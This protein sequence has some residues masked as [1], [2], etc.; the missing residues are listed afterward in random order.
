[1]P[2]HLAILTDFPEE[3]WRSMDLCGGMLLDH[4]PGDGPL[5]VD[6]G[7][8]CPPFRRLATRLPVVGRWHAAFNADRLLN[9]F[10]LFPQYARL[11]VLGCEDN[12]NGCER[13][14]S[15]QM[16]WRLTG[17]G[18]LGTPQAT[19]DEI[20][21]LTSVRGIAAL[22]VVLLHFSAVLF[23]VLPEASFL[24]PLTD[25]G[26]FAVPLFFILSGY[27]LGLRYLIRLRSPT[28]SAAMRFWWLR[29]GRVYPV[30]LCTLA[31]SLGMVAR[32]GWPADEGH[33]IGR[34]VANCLL[35]HAWECNF[36]LSWNYPSWSIS[37]EWFAYLIFP[38]LAFLLARA[39]RTW[40]A[41]L[42]G[43]ACG[44]SVG[45]Y[46]F[47]Q[48]LRF[49][50]L[51]VVLPTFVGGVG[52]AI[53]C[54]PGRSTP[55]SQPW[56]ELGLL[57]AVA[58]PFAVGPGPVLSALYLVSFF[59]LVGFLGAAGNRSAAFWQS[60]S[61][62]YLGEIS[63]SLYMTH[64]ITI[65]LMV[66]F[67]PFDALQGQPMAVRIVALLGCLIV[68]LGATVGVYHTVEWPLRNFSRRLVATPKS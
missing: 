49:E 58:F 18:G 14:A 68:I 29:L 16:V 9:R 52:L 20:A 26:I 32:H 44:L 51:A 23:R 56:A 12:V 47:R 11:A 6:A 38:L 10:I 3:G 65:T 15:E 41:V 8:L 42:V 34:F 30:H 25:A 22:W 21:S 45:V 1:M 35:A 33:T 27:V 62:V 48:H 64:A 46:A 60:Y 19:D 37:S 55:R 28:A 59:A 54:P 17:D 13:I 50:G 67:L 5:A 61:L 24:R 53:A 66:R 31:I 63:Y 7:R 43:V 39:S 40:A 57:A 4:L 2:H 36:R